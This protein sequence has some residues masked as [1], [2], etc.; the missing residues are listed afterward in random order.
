MIK[1]ILLFGFCLA[2][3]YSSYAKFEKS[4]QLHGVDVKSGKDVNGRIYEGTIKKILPH[5]IEIVLNA[6]TNFSE[7]CNNKFKNKRKYTPENIDCRFHNEN[8][9]ETFVVK[10]IHN[11]NQSKNVIDNYLLGRLVYN[12][13]TF[14]YYELITIR[15]GLNKKKQKTITV[16]SKML[17]DSEVKKFTSPKFNRE[18]AFDK[19]EWKFKL[20][21]LSENET[22]LS[23]KYSSQTNHWILN[24]EVSIPQVFESMSK[25]I[26]FLIK[27]VEEGSMNQKQTSLSKK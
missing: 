3:N 12:R 14:G 10:N 18:S 24:K 27:S 19:T 22:H 4:D 6:I 11:K 25:S 15:E 26:N 2:F 9:I 23:Y 20:T 16:S 21:Q 17:N 8:L 1:F 13:G 5:P 7:K